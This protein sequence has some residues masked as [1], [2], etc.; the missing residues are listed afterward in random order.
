MEKCSAV[1]V[2]SVVVRHLQFDLVCSDQWKQPFTSTV[3]LLGVLLGSFF[4]GQV[5]D[6]Y[7]TDSCIAWSTELLR[8]PINEGAEQVFFQEPRREDNCLHMLL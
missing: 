3:F 5:S 2:R 4:S 8:S 7:C 1:C 6:R